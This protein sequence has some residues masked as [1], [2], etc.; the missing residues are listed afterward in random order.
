MMRFL[1][2]AFL[3]LLLLPASA[4]ADICSAEACGHWY[5]PKV[6]V[7]ISGDRL[8]WTNGVSDDCAVFAQDRHVSILACT[9]HKSGRKGQWDMYYFLQALGDDLHVRS[10]S[11]LPS[12]IARRSCWPEPGA[13]FSLLAPSQR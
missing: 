1:T 8:I 5:S 13:D 3:A 7:L 4:R 11:D 2:F 9:E 10:S 12:C 6:D